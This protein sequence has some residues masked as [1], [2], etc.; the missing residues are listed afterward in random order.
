MALIT[1]QST[2]DTVWKTDNWHGE[3]Q[4]F[5]M[6]VCDF[7]RT[8]RGTPILLEELSNHDTARYV[9]QEVIRKWS[10]IKN[11][12]TRERML[13]SSIGESLN[14]EKVCRMRSGLEF[15]ITDFEKVPI[16]LGDYHVPFYMRDWHDQSK[17]FGDYMSELRSSSLLRSLDNSV[18]VYCERFPLT[19]PIPSAIHTSHWWWTMAA[20]PK[21]PIIYCDN[22][23]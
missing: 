9:V 22:D 15:L 6:S 8:A 5:L 12:L 7:C 10:T 20:V 23:E 13:L 11:A 17:P 19:T 21:D 16:F 3:V 14:A 18:R 4:A 2:I 1:L